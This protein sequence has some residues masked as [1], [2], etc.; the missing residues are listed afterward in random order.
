MRTQLMSNSAS[1]QMKT[2]K[3]TKQ[4]SRYHETP[5]SAPNHMKTP[6]STKKCSKSLQGIKKSQVAKQ[7][8]Y[9]HNF[10]HNKVAKPSAILNTFLTPKLMLEKLLL[11][12]THQ[13]TRKT[14]P[15]CQQISHSTAQISYKHHKFQAIL[16]K[17][18]IKP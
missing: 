11:M 10:A 12:T 13:I 3:F 18:V 8:S 6:K 2:P 14:K 1:N 5:I 4:C 16:H 17:S 9:Q 7:I 15:L